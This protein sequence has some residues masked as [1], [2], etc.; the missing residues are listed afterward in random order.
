MNKEALWIVRTP[1][2]GKTLETADA[3]DLL[4]RSLNF[5]AKRI[6]SGTIPSYRDGDD[7]SIPETAL[8]A[9]QAVVETFKLLD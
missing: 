9:W 6:D 5:M 1:P 4:D 7:V 2:R 3:A 8:Q